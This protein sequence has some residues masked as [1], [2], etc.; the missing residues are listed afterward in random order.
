[1]ISAAPS[2]ELSC[3]P[4]PLR[5]EARQRRRLRNLSRGNR[6]KQ[7]HFN[8]PSDDTPFFTSDYPVAIEVADL[9]EPIN[10]VILLAPDLAIRIRPDIR[11][12]RAAED[13]TFAKF[14]STKCALNR[15]EVVNLN[16]QI[17]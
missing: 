8:S 7:E 9:N 6:T 10:K 15:H 14:T 5:K 13:P 2:F 12:A 4:H 1:M 3:G 17:V 11:M 16:R